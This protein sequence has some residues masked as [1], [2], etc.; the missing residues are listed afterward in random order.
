MTKKEQAL[1]E[2][3]AKSLVQVCQERDTL[4][5]LQA[6]VLAIL[7]VFKA[8]NLAKTLSSL[9]VPRAKKLELVR[10]LQG[11]NIIYLNNFLEV[12]LQNEREAYLYQVL[13]RVLSGL[14]SVSNQYDVTVTSAVPLSEE[15]KQRVRT[16]VSK[17]LAV[18]TGRLIEKVDPSLIGGFMISV[19]NKVIDTSIRRQLQAFKMNLK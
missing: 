2:Q 8:T 4:E 1:I 6:D 19:N 12:M 15:Q 7:E 9:A 18:K 16:V 13:L 11:D 17:R 5:A 14:A 3:Y 10:Q